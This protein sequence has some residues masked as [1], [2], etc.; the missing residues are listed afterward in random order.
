MTARGEL[1][2]LGAP[3]AIAVLLSCCVRHVE[4]S[5]VPRAPHEGE[6]ATLWP[7]GLFWVLVA[8]LMTVTPM[9]GATAIA[10]AACAT[11]LVEAAYQ[12]RTG[13]QVSSDV[14]QALSGVTAELVLLFACGILTGF[15]A[16]APLPEGLKMALHHWVATPASAAGLV[17]FVLPLFSLFGAHPVVLFSLAFPLLERRV[18]GG[19]AR[20]YLVWATMFALAQLIS[21]TSTS[22]R[23][24]ASSLGL[25]ARR[26][27]WGTH[28]LFASA[29]ASAVWLYVVWV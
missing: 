14:R 8:L 13:E 29:L 7:L 6:R 1:L 2:R 22:A 15:L 19:G 17:L 11:F 10:L 24:A 3:L 25:S 26:V 9:H 28:A 21:P 18:L 5:V 23:L 12:R 4:L 20:E 16:S 27:S